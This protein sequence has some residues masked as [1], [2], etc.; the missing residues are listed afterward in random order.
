MGLDNPL[1]ILILL[2]VVLLVIILL[3]FAIASGARP[4]ICRS[5]A[6]SRS[7]SPSTGA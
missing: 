5:A 4:H 3:V 2:V 6:S 7:A 1:H